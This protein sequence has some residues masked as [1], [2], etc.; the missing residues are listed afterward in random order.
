M[1]SYTLRLTGPSARGV[2]VAGPLLRDLLDTLVDAVQQSVRLRMEGRSRASGSAPAWLERAA[3]F[4]LEIRQGS[5]QLVLQAPTLG[6]AAPE[7]FAQ[8]DLFD[9]ISPDDSCLDLFARAL[10]DALGGKEDSDLYDDGLIATLEGFDKV[11][12]HGVDRIELCNGRTRGL[13]R[14]AVESLHQ[15]RRR[16]PAEQRVRVAGKLELL[17]H[18]KRMFMLELESGEIV[19]GV[20]FTDE[21]FGA[22]PALFGEQVLI[23]GLARF[24]PSGKVLRIET[25]HVSPAEG[26]TSI[27]AKA[28]RP[29]LRSLDVRALRQSQGPKS[30]VAALFGQW[31]GD[32]TDEEFEAALRDLA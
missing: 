7:R 22:L 4:D 19:R 5:T 13:D 17:R 26:D 6:E 18:S 30:G 11:F 16:I 25:D 9:V 3:S 1:T 8:P 20:V 10:D 15:L 23:S 27:W 31:P 12:R 28:P 32:E 21:A 2:R 14:G 29:L 24:R